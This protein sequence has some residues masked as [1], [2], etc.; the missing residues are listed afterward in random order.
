[1]GKGLV[2]AYG[3]A[4]VRDSTHLFRKTACFNYEHRHRVSKF[5]FY[6]VANLALSEFPLS[7]AP[8]MCPQR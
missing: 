4:C 2:F 8:I 5:S 6:F 3:Q 1:M 7:E